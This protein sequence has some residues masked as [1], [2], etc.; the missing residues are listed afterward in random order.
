MQN[1][2]SRVSN[3]FSLFI[4]LSFV[5]YAAISLE[6]FYHYAV[7]SD[8]RMAIDKIQLHPR[9][10]Q[11]KQFNPVKSVSRTDIEKVARITFDVDADLSQMFD[12]NTKQI[13]AYVVATYGTKKFEQNEIVIWHKIIQNK[14]DAILNLKKQS[15]LLS[16]HRFNERSTNKF[17]KVK[18]KL[19]LHWDIMPHVGLLKSGNSASTKY[20]P[21]FKKT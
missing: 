14:E 6:S 15:S 10:F 18:V 5:L 3:I 11:I 4:T 13:F 2:S 20:F 9:S 19:S 16:H 1:F 12:W 8:A 17:D 21:L 7:N